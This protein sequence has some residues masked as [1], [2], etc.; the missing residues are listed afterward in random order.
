VILD[1]TSLDSNAEIKARF[2]VIGSGM[3]GSAVA[4]T[5]AAHGQDVLLVEAG[6]LK[7]SNGADSVTAVHTG[8][9]FNMPITRCIE[10]GG[11]SN[12]WHGICAPLDAIDFEQRSWLDAPGWPFKLADLLPFYEEAGPL[13]DISAASPSRQQSLNNRLHDKVAELDYNRSVMEH[14]LVF[15]RNGPMRLKQSLLGLARSRRIRCL[16][17][18]TAVEL[19]THE[20]G[21]VDRLLAG[22]GDT[23]LSI[24]AEI[25]IVCTG[26]LETPRLLLNS[27][28]NGGLAVGNDHNLVGRYLMDHPVGHFC[29]I[30]FRRPTK[31]HLFASWPVERRW[32]VTAGLVVSAEQQRNLRLA[33]HYLWIRPSVTAARID[34]ELLL[35]YLGVRG[36]RDLT[37]RQVKGILTNPD[38]LYRVLAQRF[39]MHPTF[40]YGDLF[41]MT[42]QLPNRESRVQL[43][44][45]V[46]DKHGY[47]VANVD[48]RLSDAD[49]AGFRD[50]AT[51][52]LQTGLQSAQYA[53]A[54]T[55]GLEIWERTLASAAHHLGTARIADH[56]TQGVVDRN[57]KVFGTSNL[58]VC[59]GSVF[60]SGGG[61]NPSFT[62]TAL[63]IRLGRYL[64]RQYQ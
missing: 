63:G 21:S 36:T 4:R 27:R 25:F 62:I 44:E 17:N 30:R 6:G 48:W 39:R 49:L 5:L 20:N 52:V 34:D 55:D 15:F 42:E 50:Y 3:G 13:L 19:I 61:V 9:S 56:P 31:A 24:R 18:A 45:H 57:L 8:R 35:S 26:A 54:R 53:I 16:I 29:K 41:F 46:R 37:L 64:V 1:A 60:A 43:S 14:K 32:G 10:L 47:P 33:N 11:T 12:R 23:T 2:C 28:H 38:I 40:R 22:T 59:D 51:L 58:Y 7:A